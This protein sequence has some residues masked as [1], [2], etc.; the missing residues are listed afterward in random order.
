M[1]KLDKKDIEDIL[2]LTPVQE[3]M[4]FHYLKD[5]GRDYYFEQLSLKIS[6][7]IDIKCFEQAWNFVIQTN[8]MLRAVFRYET[9]E[10]PVQMVLKEHRLEPKYYDFSN[11]RTEKKQELRE[12][13]KTKDRQETFDLRHVP[14]RV[15]LCKIDESRYEMVVSNHHIL[16]DGWSSGI[17]LRE[18]L[19]SYSDLSEQKTPVRPVK[20][21]FK[22]YLKWLEKQDAVKQEKYWREYLKDFDTASKIPVKHIKAK[23]KK[24][25]IK[26]A[27][28]HCFRL[29]GDIKDKLEDFV[30]R[31]K[32][33]FAALLYASWGLLLQK[34]NNTNDVIFGTT[35]SGRSAKIKSIEDIVGLFINTVPLRVQTWPDEAISDLLYRINKMLQIREEY[36]STPLV[37]IKECI[38]MSTALDTKEELFDSIVV[39]ENYPLDRRLLKEKGKLSIDS[40]SMKEMTHYDLTIGITRFEEIEISFIYNEG[41]FDNESIINMS[42]HFRKIIQAIVNHPDT[43]ISDIEIITEEEKNK[44]LYDFN[45]TGADYPGDKTI[46]QLF[47]EQAERTGDRVAVIGMEHGAWGMEGIGTLETLH[48]PCSMLHTITYEE[49]NKKS[50]QL[51]YWLREKGVKPNTIVGVMVEPSMQMMIGIFGILKSGGAYLPIDPDYPRERIR[52]M[53]ADSAVDVLVTTRNLFKEGEKKEIICLDNYKKLGSGGASSETLHAPCAMLHVSSEKH[54]ATRNPQPATSSENLAYIIYTSG[55]TGKPKGVLVEH[56]S[57]I[58]TLFALDEMY[59]LEESDVYLLKTSYTFDVSVTELFGWFFSGGAVSVLEKGGEKDPYMIMNTVETSGVTHINFVPSMF[60]VF[61]DMLDRWNIGK[62]SGLKY[63]F[64]AGEALMPGVV[65]KFRALNSEILL[66]NIYGPTEATIYAS[67]YSLSDWDSM[68]SIPIGR[69]LPNV[70]FYILDTHGHIQPVGVTGELCI[71]GAGVVRGYLNRPELTAEKFNQDFQDYHDYQDE[72]GLK[73]RSGKY[74]FTSLPLYPSTSFYRT[75]D[76]ARWLPDSNIEYMGR[77]DQ[78]VKIRGFRVELGEIESCLLEHPLIKEAVVI[79]RDE[80]NEETY[81][82]AYFVSE[83][84]LGPPELKEFLALTLPDYMIP[85]YFVCMDKIPLTSHGKVDRKALPDPVFKAGKRYIAPENEIEQKLVEI[86]AGVLQID[87]DMIGIKDSFFELGGHSL[88]SIRLAGEIHKAFGVKIDLDKIFKSPYITSLSKY[89]QESE[90]MIY[91]SIELVEKRE[92]YPVSSAQKRMFLLNHLKGDD[93]SDNSPGAMCLEGCINKQYIEEVLKELIKRHEILRT[94][95]ELRDINPVQVVHKDVE[96]RINYYELDE[97]LAPSPRDPAILI[98]NFVRP[99]DLS[100]APLLR[101]DLVKISQEQYILM[102]DR[103]HITTDDTSSAIFLNDFIELYRG[104]ELAESAVQYKD[105]A[106]WQNDLLQSERVKKQEEYWAGVFQNGVPVLNLPTDFPRPPVQS[107]EGRYIRFYFSCDLTKRLNRMALETKTTLYMVLLAIYNVLLARYSGQDDIVVGTPI[108]GRVHPDLQNIMGF[109]INTLAMHHF[110]KGEK[111]FGEFLEEVKSNSL[112]AFENQD[113]QFDQLIDRLGIE[114]NPGRQKMFDTMFVVQNVDIN[115]EGLLGEIKDVTFRPYEFQKQA[116]QFDILLH[117]FEN[118]T[119]ISF[120]LDYCTKLFKEETMVRLMHHMENI[121]EE[122]TVDPLLKIS[123][124]KVF[125]ENEKAELSFQSSKE[126]LDHIEV[127]FN[128]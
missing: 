52:Y 40:Y 80:G 5:S 10:N 97:P 58:N 66:E 113:Y 7:E 49:L 55:S 73:K 103:H 64:L 104:G 18:F 8:E 4:L 118:D 122:V 32:I 110:P 117:A 85:A 126:K 72:K 28:P 11:K 44:L 116:T 106:C 19:Q 47:E 111:T 108:A 21:K 65:K 22:E 107:F 62:L 123:E 69:P 57:V 17:I 81:L 61:V 27:E 102:Y 9:V 30:K 48:A 86:W 33:T 84:T 63:I 120:R 67:K 71:D 94:S 91:E 88:K 16:Y 124:I 99:F 12:E 59:P 37:R 76:L 70:K 125:S 45:N 98:E 31:Y 24:A 20:N 34:Y 53:L 119:E 109:F 75:G 46:H 89:I 87:K 115:L 3:G 101:V 77:I 29:T 128:F 74:S 56:R 6:G 50:D 105:F 112:K 15:T 78:Q 25:E 42:C 26:G 23:A 38:N 13:I 96:F 121:A 100:Q 41:V 114:Q 93:I 14:F 60:N 127:D 92:Y 2:A 36:E 54:R 68:G 43:K 82:C 90:G 95:F 1:K 79:D 35:I 51:A 39:I 83:K